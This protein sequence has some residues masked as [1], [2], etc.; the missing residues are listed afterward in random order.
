MA[1]RGKAISYRRDVDL[2]MDASPDTNNNDVMSPKKDPYV[3]RISDVFLC[4]ISEAKHN[5][6]QLQHSARNKLI[7]NTFDDRHVPLPVEM[8]PHLGF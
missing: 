8:P 5:P 7:P 1:C 4:F 6:C 3:Y 2:E